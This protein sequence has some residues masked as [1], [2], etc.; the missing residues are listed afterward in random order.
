MQIRGIRLCNFVSGMA[1]TGLLTNKKG[2]PGI[3]EMDR[4]R[5]SVMTDLSCREDVAA[6]MRQ[7]Y[8]ED[9][10]ERD[11]DYSRFASGILFWW[12]DAVILLGVVRDLL[13]DRRVHK[14]YLYGLPALLL[15]QN[16]A[17]YLWR[18]SP[19]WWMRVCKE[20]LGI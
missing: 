11:V 17:I 1:F 6:M 16:V 8:D 3:E 10:G 5:F 15:G 18:G 19:A 4:I 12:L 9:R 2:A 7:L 14:V 13:V 20:T